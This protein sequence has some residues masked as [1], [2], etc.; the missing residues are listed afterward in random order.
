MKSPGEDLEET[1]LGTY[2]PQNTRKTRKDSV[3]RSCFSRI[4]WLIEIGQSRVLKTD[5]E[6]N[7]GGLPEKTL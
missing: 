2:Q 4:S 7:S 5:S 3:L 6:I 1:V